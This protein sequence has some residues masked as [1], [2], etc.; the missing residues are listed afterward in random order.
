MS[1]TVTVVDYGLGNLFSVSRALETVGASPKVTDSP[2]DIDAA[3]C[4]VLPGV[5]AFRDGMEGLHTRRLVEPLR[6]YG[7]SGRRLLGICL[8]MQL[9]FESSEEF[10]ANE[11]LSLIPGGVLAIPPVGN[12]GHA[13]KI[14]HIGWNE[15]RIPSTREHWQGTILKNTAPGTA[16]YFVHSYNC[17][18]TQR[19]DLLAYADYDGC[20]IAAAVQHDRIYGLQFHPEKSGVQGLGMLNQFVAEAQET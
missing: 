17:V 11:G 14:P 6:R 7:A 16:V 8:G 12:D 18:P 3:T 4:L 20:A 9:L 2:R 13:R 1:V 15:L 10:G 19:R 5:G